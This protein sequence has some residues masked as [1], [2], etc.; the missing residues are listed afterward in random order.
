MNTEQIA[1]ILAAAML[2]FAIGYSE[3]RKRGKDE[4]Y[5]DDVLAN[6]RS[7]RA[8][9]DAAGRFKRVT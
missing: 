3:G 7:D 5:V 1:V 6:W 2:C 9:R 4:Q 8:R